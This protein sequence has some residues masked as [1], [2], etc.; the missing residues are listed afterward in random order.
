MFFLIFPILQCV[1]LVF[2]KSS[3]KKAIIK[4]LSVFEVPETP[5][6]WFS[7]YFLKLFTSSYTIMSHICVKHPAATLARP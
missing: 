5:L 7:L 6:Q 2:R 4:S 1:I 3:V